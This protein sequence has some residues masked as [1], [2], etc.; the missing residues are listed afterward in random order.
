MKTILALS[1]MAILATGAMVP[2]LQEAYA[3][4]PSSHGEKTKLKMSNT[5][6][7]PKTHKGNFD[8]VK[9]ESIKTTKKISENERALQIFKNLYRLG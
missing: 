4:A 6:N 3:A 2:A 9:K 1:I 7:E 8:G 5:D